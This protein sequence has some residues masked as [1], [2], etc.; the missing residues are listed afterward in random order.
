MNIGLPQRAVRMVAVL[1]WTGLLLPFT[2]AAT[3]AAAPAPPEV[4]AKADTIR[5]M[6]LGDSITAGVGAHGS[7]VKDG[8]YR[9]ALAS[10]L[11]REG[12]HVNFVGSRTDYSDAIDERAHEGW[13]GYVL[14]SFPS[15]PGP[16]Q[17]YGALV[18]SAIAKDDPDVILLMAGTNDL[19]RLEKHNAGYTLP[20]YSQFHEPGG[21]SNSGGKTE[22]LSDRST[23]R[24]KSKSRFV[25]PCGVCGKCGMRFARRQSA[26]DRRAL[27]GAWVSRHA[28]KLDGIGRA[29]RRS[30][31][32]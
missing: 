13:P 8:G 28:C 2:L 30:A 18:K 23:R 11:Q 12:Y 32:S 29:S 22:R 27:R 19:L 6:A 26:H 17:L 24:C 3:P 4:L 14:R 10:L 15:D 16:G 5:V 1:L 25:Q 31:F 20:E 7:R 21:Q 9:G